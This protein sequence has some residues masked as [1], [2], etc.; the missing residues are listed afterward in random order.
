MAISNG[1]TS[2]DQHQSTA[3]SPRHKPGQTFVFWTLFGVV[4]ISLQ[5]GVH[6]SVLGQWLGGSD[7]AYYLVV[8]P[9]VGASFTIL[10]YVLRGIP[11]HGR[12]L[13][14]AWAIAFAASFIYWLWWAPFMIIVAGAVGLLMDRFL[15]LPEPK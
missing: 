8:A 7:V 1:P 13:I 10:R 3:G 6:P 2:T 14:I 15:P 11:N 12:W 4:C 5:L 9:L